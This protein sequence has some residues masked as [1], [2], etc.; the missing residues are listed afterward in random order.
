MLVN[1]PSNNRDIWY[2]YN[3]I[4]H[5]CR[6]HAG[7]MH[8]LTHIDQWQP[9]PPLWSGLMMQIL[10]GSCH[11]LLSEDHLLLSGCH[12][13]LFDESFAGSRVDVHPPQGTVPRHICHK[14]QRHPTT[15][16]HALWVGVP[17]QLGCLCVCSGGNLLWGTL[18]EKT[19]HAQNTICRKH[20]VQKTSNTY[21]HQHI[22]SSRLTIC[23]TH[24][25]F[26]AFGWVK[27]A[28]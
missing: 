19:P 23:H 16:T 28:D 25:F 9:P 26:V 5:A 13:L 20:H 6:T 14:R 11:H 8:I 1:Q 27:Y 24:H 22:I 21:Q 18:Y 15:L 2:I 10:F 7:C 4:I 3:K 12:H 17:V